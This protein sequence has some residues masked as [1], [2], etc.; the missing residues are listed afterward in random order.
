MPLETLVK[1]KT[2]LPEPALLQKGSPVL[3]APFRPWGKSPA[4]AATLR[5]AGVTPQNSN[6]ARPAAHGTLPERD[7]PSDGPQHLSRS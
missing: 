7:P 5:A 2:L 3:R 1:E 4:P 6:Q